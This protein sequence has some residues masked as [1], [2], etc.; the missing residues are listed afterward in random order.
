[1]AHFF[2]TPVAFGMGSKAKQKRCLQ[3]VSQSDDGSYFDILQA[4][5]AHTA[6]PEDFEDLFVCDSRGQLLEVRQIKMKARKTPP[7]QSR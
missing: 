1:M 6:V 5:L 4:F 3:M 2:P 7:P